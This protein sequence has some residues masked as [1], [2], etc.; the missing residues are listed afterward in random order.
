MTSGVKEN[1]SSNYEKL[2]T[3]SSS[4][5]DIHYKKNVKQKLICRRSVHERLTGNDN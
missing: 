3:L 2:V 1:P 5:D 4:S